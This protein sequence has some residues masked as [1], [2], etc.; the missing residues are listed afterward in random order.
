MSYL[1][2]LQGLEWE[3]FHRGLKSQPGRVDELFL[4]EGKIKHQV[5]RAAP[6]PGSGSG[7]HLEG[8][9]FLQHVEEELELQQRGGVGG[10]GGQRQEAVLPA[11]G[12]QV[13]LE[14][15]GQLLQAGGRQGQ[16]AAA[17]QH[18]VAWREG[19]TIKWHYSL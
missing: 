12:Q 13:L 4:E 2:V 5:I 8:D 7:S 19:E 11:P 3:D 17:V 1:Q 10:V 16:R 18:Q 14:E 6:G 9:G 15:A